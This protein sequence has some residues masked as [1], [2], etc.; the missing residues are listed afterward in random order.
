[1]KTLI[2]FLAIIPLITFGQTYSS[3]IPD[4]TIL[5]FIKWEI[6]NGEKFSEDSKFS[7]N[8]KTSRIISEYDTINFFLPKSINRGDWQNEFYLFNRRNAI[9]SLFSE[10]EKDFLFAQYLALKDTIWSHKLNR[11]RIKKWKNSRNIYTYAIPLFSSNEKY[12]LIKKSFYCGN[13]CAYGGIYLYEKIDEKNWKLLK[14]LN[15]WIS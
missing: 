10:T 5:S 2:I 15:G 9:D 12:V 1:M 11:A 14:I 13:V 7:F 8:K 4:S 6:K 3:K